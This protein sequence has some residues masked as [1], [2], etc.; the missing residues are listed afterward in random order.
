MLI[1]H[2]LKIVEIQFLKNMTFLGR[3]FD[4]QISNETDDQD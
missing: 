2:V 3:L 4:V 1:E